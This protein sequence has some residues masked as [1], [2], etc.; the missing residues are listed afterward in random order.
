MSVLPRWARVVLICALLIVLAALTGCR[1]VPLEQHEAAL[2]EIERLSSDLAAAGAEIDAREQRIA[3]L[4][5]EAEALREEL[6]RA[7]DESD[8]LQSDLDVALNRLGG[9]REERLDLQQEIT[10]IEQQVEELRSAAIAAQRAAEAV[11]AAEAAARDGGIDPPDAMAAALRG[12]GGFS[13]I[14]DLG[15]QNDP[16]AA[17]R[18]S[19]A[20]P[21]IG[22]DVS[23]GVPILY[24]SRLD[25]EKTAVYL[26]IVDPEGRRPRLRLTAQY[27]T[28]VEPLYLRTAFITI[29]G[30]DP[31][32]PIDPIV[33]S[34]EPVRQTDGEL[35]REALEMNAE[36]ELVDRLSTMISSRRFQVTF[37][38]LSEQHTHRPSVSERS[39]MSNMLF[40][41]IDLGGVE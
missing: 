16:R 39:A 19:A 23:I 1:T 35:L 15:F 37:V 36:G 17:A 28:E 14:R 13:R 31:V 33:L 41:F 30:G 9:L 40:A 4:E 7:R 34:G 20:A 32:D 21:G 29:E 25:Y 18:L 38:G 5:T 3:D 10:A 12:G 11:E 22:V 26:S 24:D 2:D 27:S 8:R 6:R